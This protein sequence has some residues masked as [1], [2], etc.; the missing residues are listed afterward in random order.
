MKEFRSPQNVH[1]P[2][3]NSYTHQIEV[4]EPERL[5]IFSGQVGI[6]EDGAVPA[7]PI[8]QLD[9]AL[10]RQIWTCQIL[11]R[12]RMEYIETTRSDRIQ[13]QRT[14]TLFDVD[15]C[16]GARP[17]H[18]QNRDRCMGKSCELNLL[19]KEDI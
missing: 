5:L 15:L 19:A 12:G 4:K 18:L 14:Q 16:H 8:E 17:S 10:M 11:C 3:A 9:V 6:K 13:T 7:D 1:P 2:I